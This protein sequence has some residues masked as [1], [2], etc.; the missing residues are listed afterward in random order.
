[1]LIPPP[2]RIVEWVVGLTVGLT[3][4]VLNVAK[5]VKIYTDSRRK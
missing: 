4:I 1:M 3:I 5:L 2:E